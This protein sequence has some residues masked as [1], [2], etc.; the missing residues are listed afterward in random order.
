MHL[1]AVLFD[2]DGTL[3]DTAGDMGAAANHVVNSLGLPLLSEAI[4]QSTCSDGA[5]ALLRA[6]V[7]A[8]LIE[9]HGIEVLRKQMLDFYRD[10]LCYHT[11]P[12]NGVPSLLNWLTQAQVPWGVVTNKPAMLTEP[13][14]VSLPLFAGC[15][16]T[17]S[18]D[19]LAYKKPHPAP[20]LY[21][22]EQ[23]SVAPEHCVYIGDHKRDIEAGHA[24]GMTTIAAEWGYISAGED[25]THWQAHHHFASA[26][27]LDQW[28]KDTLKSET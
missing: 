18:A 8:T 12:Y 3:L 1:Q 28:L 14:L 16:V 17:V 23:L 10:N 9:R 21:A 6:G 13:L 19:T 24:A 2:L 22:A 4:L 26:S 25:P 15:G 11:R 5:Y 27:A 20:L 7:P